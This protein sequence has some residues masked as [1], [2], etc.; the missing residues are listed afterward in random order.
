MDQSTRPPSLLSPVHMLPFPVQQSPINKLQSSGLQGRVYTPVEGSANPY[1]RP[2]S[3][4]LHYCG[5][6]C[7]PIIP[8]LPVRVYTPVEGS[9]NPLRW[10]LSSCSGFIRDLIGPTRRTHTSNHTLG[11]SVHNIA[12]QF[13]TVFALLVLAP[14]E[15]CESTRLFCFILSSFEHFY[16]LFTI[17][18]PYLF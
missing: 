3:T 15:D 1:S 5:R 6:V 13:P 14:R 11:L 4:C 2:T 7:Q 17:L 16:L 10:S 12:P 18:F 8:D 9:A